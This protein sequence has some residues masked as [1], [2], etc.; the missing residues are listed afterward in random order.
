MESRSPGG[1]ESVG[2]EKRAKITERRRKDGEREGERERL[3]KK[4]DQLAT[5]EMRCKVPR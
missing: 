2:P 4:A 1:V 5:P 3:V